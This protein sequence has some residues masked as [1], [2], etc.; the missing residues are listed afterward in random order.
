MDNLAE[1][2]K[3]GV[4]TLPILNRRTGVSTPQDGDILF[5]ENENSTSEKGLFFYSTEKSVHWRSV[6]MAGVRALVLLRDLNLDDLKATILSDLVKANRLA[7]ITAEGSDKQIKSAYGFG[8]KQRIGWPDGDQ[9]RFT[10]DLVELTIV[11]GSGVTSA[12]FNKLLEAK[13]V[14]MA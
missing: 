7:I 8:K 6:D 5:L 2:W 12:V 11:R 9:V 1:Y 3:R 4:T 14:K 13:L 10:R